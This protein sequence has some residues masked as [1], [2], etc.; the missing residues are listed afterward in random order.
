MAKLE[1][2]ARALLTNVSVSLPSTV[3]TAVAR[4]MGI[5][6]S[7]TPAELLREFP[8]DHFATEVERAS[9]GRP[10]FDV[11]RFALRT[12][13]EAGDQEVVKAFRARMAA[14]IVEHYYVNAG[15][16][17]ANIED[18]SRVNKVENDI[19]MY[20]NFGE[21]N[22]KTL[23]DRLRLDEALRSS[24]LDA[25]EYATI[26][27]F[28]QMKK[29][30]AERVEEAKKRLAKEREDMR[31]AKQIAHEFKMSRPRRAGRKANV[32]YLEDADSDDDGDGGPPPRRRARV[33]NRPRSEED[34][35]WTREEGDDDDDD[36][37]DGGRLDLSL[38]DA[39]DDDP[40]RTPPKRKRS[41]KTRTGV[42]KRERSV[43]TGTAVFKSL[44]MEED[45]H[46]STWD[47]QIDARRRA[48]MV[49]SDPSLEA[50]HPDAVVSAVL[51]DGTT[52]RFARTWFQEDEDAHDARKAADASSGGN[53]RAD[54]DVDYLWNEALDQMEEE[55]DDDTDELAEAF[56]ED[57][58]F[59]RYEVP[60][61]VKEML[62]AK[63]TTPARGGDDDGRGDDASPPPLLAPMAAILEL[64]HNRT[65]M[66][67]LTITAASRMH[68]ST[69]QEV[70]S[71]PRIVALRRARHSSLLELAPQPTLQKAPR[72]QQSLVTE[73]R[74]PRP[75]PGQ[76]QSSI[77]PGL[78]TVARV[79]EGDEMEVDELVAALLGDEVDLV[80]AADGGTSIRGTLLAMS[81]HDRDVVRQTRE[82][83]LSV[84][85]VHS[86]VASMPSKKGIG[87]CSIQA[88][89]VEA[90]HPDFVASLT[91]YNFANFMADNACDSTRS[92]RP[93]HKSKIK[94]EAGHDNFTIGVWKD[95]GADAV[96]YIKVVGR[97]A[98]Q[99]RVS[100]RHGSY[101]DPC[102]ANMVCN[103]LNSQPYEIRMKSNAGRHF[104]DFLMPPALTADDVGDYVGFSEDRSDLR[105]GV[106]ETLATPRPVIWG[107]MTRPQTAEGTL[108][109]EFYPSYGNTITLVGKHGKKHRVL[110]P[111]SS[112]AARTD[113][114][115]IESMMHSFVGLE[116]E[117]DKLLL[118]D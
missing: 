60:T 46:E 32:S 90:L 61:P 37:D 27:A 24:F 47:L 38:L 59:E 107:K 101:S 115:Y 49:R 70:Q 113:H 85:V 105:Q 100:V 29:D 52:L 28:E 88:A 35:D 21:D 36:S 13:Y 53:A 30:E 8:D 98:K 86:H 43:R 9:S 117:V 66:E 55:D 6:T 39:L 106:D 96:P 67:R 97:D 112:M 109:A 54:D 62:D 110:M 82:L 75:W 2:A 64:T 7:T 16:D 103:W 92:G 17:K 72:P 81:D 31:H 94:T 80:R 111:F 51:D 116:N 5:L 14:S 19:V 89:D 15:L 78:A 79:P 44:V 42:P 20:Y 99:K 65:D 73:S 40:M 50:F 12:L 48:T 74:T 118:D 108:S 87:V 34:T 68:L 84:E 91:S 114:V 71:L 102:T 63:T 18:R 58:A 104:L 56:V 45:A 26:A 77:V 10:V 93:A 33:P 95:G 69:P 1:K 3:D 25:G 11:R 4:V 83:D 22:T 23:M 76:T 41:K 57:E